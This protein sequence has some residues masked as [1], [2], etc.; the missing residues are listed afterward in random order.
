MLRFRPRHL[1]CHVG[2]DKGE[3]RQGNEHFELLNKLL[4]VSHGAFF[5]FGRNQHERH[6]DRLDVMLDHGRPW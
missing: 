5:G 3:R 4:V 1:H 2:H 6:R